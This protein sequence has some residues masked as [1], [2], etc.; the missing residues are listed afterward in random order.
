M[1]YSSFDIRKYPVL[2]VKEGYK[3]WAKTY[4]Q[5]VS[6]EMDLKLLSKIKSISWAQINRAL[7]LACGTGRIGV[8]LKEQSVGQ[9]DGI[10]ITPEMLSK[11]SEKNIYTS[12]INADILNAQLQEGI[13][14]LCIQVL[15]DEHFAD[16]SSLYSEVS[17]ILKNKG[18]FIIVGYHPFFLMNGIIT[19]F[20]KENGDPLAIESY[21]HLFS[22]HVKAAYR[23]NLN[24]IEMDEGIIDADW[25]AKKPKWKKYENWPVS[26]SFVWQKK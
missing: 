13:Y 7:D 6:D 17:R 21:V 5:T 10:D 16:I 11:A 4:E 8:W 23:S 15:A 19:H 20:H 18:Y 22:D 24:L 26:Y 9:I 12:L 25:I 14:D 3:E 2:P 1:E